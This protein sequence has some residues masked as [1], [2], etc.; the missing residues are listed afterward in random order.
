MKKKSLMKKLL[1]S[2]VLV[3]ALSL[4]HY[5]AYDKGEA[6]GTERGLAIG[7]I[8]GGDNGYWRGVFTC[9][10]WDR[11]GSFCSLCGIK[12]TKANAFQIINER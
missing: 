10:C 3:A 8:L 11:E 7:L 2:A 1:G 5:F 9:P 12:L 6:Y 4:S